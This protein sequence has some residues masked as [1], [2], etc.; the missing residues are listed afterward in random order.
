LH[1]DAP[2]LGVEVLGP[3]LLLEALERARV[4]VVGPPRSMI[5]PGLGDDQGV[6]AVLGN[7]DV[8]SED[9]VTVKDRTDL[10]PATRASRHPESPDLGDA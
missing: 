10:D 1:L 9:R 8:R 5:T 2:Q 6:A 7:G 4:R 3:D